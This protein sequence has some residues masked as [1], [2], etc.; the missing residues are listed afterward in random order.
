MV[1][2]NVKNKD[3][4]VKFGGYILLFFCKFVFGVKVKEGKV[5]WNLGCYCGWFLLIGRVCCGIKSF[6]GSRII[7]L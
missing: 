6:V 1:E 2:V 3:C 5:D 4:K 7:L